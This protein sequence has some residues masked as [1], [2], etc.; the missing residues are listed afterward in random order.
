MRRRT[1]T[2]RVETPFG[3]MYVHVELDRA[4]RPVSGSISAPGKNPDSAVD[5]MLAALS[6][7]LDGALAAAGAEADLTAGK[8]N[9]PP[10]QAGGDGKGIDHEDHEGDEE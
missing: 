6:A 7:G 3:A 10:D 4:A 9:W 5:T 2:E 1:V 8:P